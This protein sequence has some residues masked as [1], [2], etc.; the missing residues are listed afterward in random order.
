MNPRI[1]PRDGAWYCYG[2]G[3][4]AWAICP[5]MAY[6]LWLRRARPYADPYADMRLK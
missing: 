3:H 1:V 4:E 6:R 2:R 5:G